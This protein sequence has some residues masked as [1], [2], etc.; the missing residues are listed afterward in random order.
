L[1]AL[2]SEQTTPFITGVCRQPLWASQE[3]AVQG[4]PSSQLTGNPGAQDPDW[5]VD[6][7]EHELPGPHDVPS[8]TATDTQPWAGSHESLVQALL[9]SHPSGAPAVHTPA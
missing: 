5:Q 9:S 4:L 3:S 7:A 2:P 6:P 8:P 1:Q